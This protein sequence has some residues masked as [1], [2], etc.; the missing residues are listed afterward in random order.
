MFTIMS[1]TIIYTVSTQIQNLYLN[2][3]TIIYSVMQNLSY[4]AIALSNPGIQT[5]DTIHT[6][7]QVNENQIKR[8]LFV[9]IIRFCKRCG[10][11]M[12]QGTHHCRD[13]D[14]CIR[15]YDHHCPWTSKCIG[16]KNLCKFYVFVTLTLTYIVYCMIVLL[17]CSASSALEIN[18][19]LSGKTL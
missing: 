2:I 3:I 17:I 8:Y 4:L 11:R 12:Q 19:K 7:E 10:I 15:D 18:S 13:C 5:S 14:V 16:E 9:F 1:F 6:E